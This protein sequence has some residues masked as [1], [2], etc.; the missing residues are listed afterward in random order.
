MFFKKLI[1]SS[2]ENDINLDL[3]NSILQIYQIKS[4]ISNFLQEK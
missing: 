1:F 2:L 3:N 4:A